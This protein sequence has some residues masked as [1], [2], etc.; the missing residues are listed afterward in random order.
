METKSAQTPP[1][2]AASYGLYL[3][4]Y[5]RALGNCLADAD[6]QRHTLADRAAVALAIY[7]AR[8]Q[9]DTGPLTQYQFCIDVAR[10]LK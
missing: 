7:H 1:P 8:C 4:I 5:A 3:T 6:T 9:T 2:E 10:M